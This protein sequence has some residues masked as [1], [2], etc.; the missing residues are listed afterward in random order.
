MTN[1]TATGGERPNADCGSARCRSR[2]AGGFLNHGGS[3]MQ[4]DY[5]HWLWIGI[6]AA[7]VIFAI[8]AWLGVLVAATI[9][10]TGALYGNH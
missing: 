3:T 2:P 4:D 5:G 8:T 9:R 7:F 1:P 6:M 10:F